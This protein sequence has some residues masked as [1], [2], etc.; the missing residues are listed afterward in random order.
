MKSHLFSVA[1]ILVSG[2]VAQ[3]NSGW[4]C[5]LYSDRDYKGTELIVALNY[6]E[7]IKEYPYNQGWNFT[8]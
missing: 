4:F 1:A 2:A 6:Y 5:Y 8:Y 7:G 3:A